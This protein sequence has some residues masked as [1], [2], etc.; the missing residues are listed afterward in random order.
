MFRKSVPVLAI[1]ALVI[2]LAMLG[3]ALNARPTSAQDGSTNFRGLIQS[4]MDQ[5]EPFTINTRVTN[6][7]ID[8]STNSIS[9]LGDDFVCVTGD[10]N[11]MGNS[12]QTVCS[13]FD[14]MIVIIH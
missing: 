1:A 5:G 11:V 3:A 10:L 12:M 7:E 9:Q 6:F 2:G 14:S 8:G 4:L 13:A